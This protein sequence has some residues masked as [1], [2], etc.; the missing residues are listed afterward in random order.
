[1]RDLSKIEEL[2]ELSDGRVGLR[3]WRAD[4]AA[5]AAAMC[6]DIGVARWMPLMPH[7]YTLAD[8]LE[9]VGDAARKWTEESWANFAAVDAVT[10]ALVG[11]CGLR[12]D[13]QKESGEIGYLVHRRRRREGIAAA[14]V[15]LLTA[16]GFDELELG[17]VQIRADVRNVAS[18][19]TIVAAGYRFEAVMRGVETVRGERVDD[20]L[21]ALL[22][23]DLRPGVGSPAGAADRSSGAAAGAAGLDTAGAAT[24]RGLGWPEL[25]DDRLVVRPF[26][27]DDAPAVQAACGD[28][29]VAHWIYGVP[30]PYTADDAAEFVAD[31]RHRLLLGERARM[32]ICDAGPGALLG[33]ISLDLFADRQAA[34]IGYWVK[35]EARRRGVALAAARLV[36]RW[37]FEEV[38]VERLEILTYPGNG[39]SQA[40]AE[41]L[42]FRREAL[43]SGF[44][45][46]E[47]GKSRGGR[48]VPSDDGSLPPRDDQVQ[49]AL[50]RGEWPGPGS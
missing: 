50:L 40:L 41:K 13:V 8:G 42:G 35:H 14:C 10:G 23:G 21:Y 27:P 49:F 3:P 26:A 12:V 17:R 34:E 29:D 5:A 48:V 37:A 2:P 15:R 18:R 9:W 24:L 43:L 28:P 6:D 4:D 33:S 7:P 19:R 45:A 46:P 11:S 22:P 47:P 44:L 30:T 31:S 36:V 25:T 20:V 1:M 39:A 16:W 38:G 32:A